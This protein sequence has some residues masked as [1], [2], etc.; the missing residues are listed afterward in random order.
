VARGQE[1]V[2]RRPA[3]RGVLALA[4]LMILATGCTGA[5]TPPAPSTSPTGGHLLWWDISTLTGALAA[6]KSLA[7][8]FVQANPGTTVDVEVMTPD[9]AHGKFDTAVQTAAAAPDVITVLASWIPDWSARGYIGRLDDTVAADGAEDVL[10]SLLPMQK[11]DGRIMAALRSADGLALLYNPDLMRRAGLSVPRTWNDVAADNSKLTALGVQT[12]YAPA[13]G[14]GLLPWIYGEGGTL[15]DPEA[16][17]IDISQPPAVAG[18]SRRVQMQ[19]TGVAV[20]DST[21]WKSSSTPPNEV[22]TTAMRAAFRQGRV[23]MILDDADSL[24]LLVGGPAF[25]SR[26][27][28]GIATV[29]AGTVRASGPVTATGYAVF[30]GSHNLAAAYSFVKFI[31][32][33]TSQAALAEQLGLL[34]TRA[35]AYTPDV[36]KAD[37][38]LGAFLPVLRGGTPLPQ[39]QT[40]PSMLF[41]PDDNFRAALLGDESPQTAL[42]TVAAAWQKD[43]NGGYTIGPATG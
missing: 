42:D 18:L 21:L 26:S 15:V 2:V 17:T 32:S 33:P 23:A 31:Q 39:V 24:P 37:P 29:P 27:S 20:D 22:T 14:E 6:D 35:A 40:Q 38:V 28:V 12:L 1:V 9:Q 19:A 43:L 13:T 5:S 11:Y 8:Q 7:E 4:A 34:P 25:A 30:S 3:V 10:P 41:A 36:V 16:K